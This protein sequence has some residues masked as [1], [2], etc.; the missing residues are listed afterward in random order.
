MK[1]VVTGVHFTVHDKLQNYVTKKITGLEKYI[2]R[3]AREAAIAD[4]RLKESKNKERKEYICEVTLELP[5]E[6]IEASDSTVNIFAAVD[7]VE[8]KLKGQ[9]KKYKETH[10]SP[11]LRQRIVRKFKRTPESV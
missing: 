8:A 10:A 9:L 11:R 4:V 2:P 1:L 5:H 7:I 6:V 3:K